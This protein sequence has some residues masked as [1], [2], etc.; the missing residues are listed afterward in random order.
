MGA[1]AGESGVSTCEAWSVVEEEQVFGEALVE[2]RGK[3]GEY[4]ELFDRTVRATNLAHLYD[5]FG[6]LR[7]HAGQPDERCGGGAVA[8]T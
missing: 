6:Q 8:A 3:F 2:V 5:A 4:A 1:S 7:S